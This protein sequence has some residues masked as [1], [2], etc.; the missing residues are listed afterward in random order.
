MS[1]SRWGSSAWYSFWSTGSGQEKENQI[2]ELWAGIDACLGWKYSELKPDI[3]FIKENYD[4][5]CLSHRDQIEAVE[6]IKSFI[7]D[8]DSEYDTEVL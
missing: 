5:E 8:V 1:Y 3:N 2:L 7:E 6:I 4:C